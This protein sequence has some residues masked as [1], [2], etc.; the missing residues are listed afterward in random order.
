MEYERDRN[1]G[2]RASGAG[3]QR[4]RGGLRSNVGQEGRR[5]EGRPALVPQEEG[6]SVL[7]TTGGRGTS[8]TQVLPEGGE[9][10]LQKY[11]RREGNQHYPSTKEE[12]G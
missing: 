12:G 4:H 11:Y 2:D 1:K 7:S 8:T 3:K 5:R 6:D 9:P 10:V